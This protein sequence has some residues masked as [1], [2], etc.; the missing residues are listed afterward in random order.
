MP[1]VKVGSNQDGQRNQESNDVISNDVTNINEA[2]GPSF[3]VPTFSIKRIPGVFQAESPVLDTPEEI[4]K[5]ALNKD[6]SHFIDR[7]IRLRELHSRL[8]L[9]AIISF[10]MAVSA[11]CLAVVDIE[12]SKS[13]RGVLARTLNCEETYVSGYFR[14][15]PA[16]VDPDNVM[17]DDLINRTIYDELIRHN[18]YFERWIFAHKSY[19]MDYW[20]VGIVAKAIITI[21]SIA[22][23]Y[24]SVSYYVAEVDVLKLKRYLPEDGQFA[25]SPKI[26]SFAL[27][28]LLLFL[29]VPPLTDAWID[30]QFQLLVGIRTVVTG[31]KVLKE[32][33]ELRYHGLGNVLSNLARIKI[34]GTFLL[35]TYFLRYPQTSLLFVYL[36][37]IAVLPYLLML[38]EYRDG[39]ALSFQD[40][41]WLMVVTVTNL[42]S[43]EVRPHTVPARAVVGFASLVG[44]VTTALWV[45]VISKYMELPQEER[46]ILAMVEHQRIRNLER[47]KAAMCIQA[48]WRLFH[49]QQC[50]ERR[51]ARTVFLQKACK[52]AVWDWKCIRQHCDRVRRSMESTFSTEDT[53]IVARNMARRMST[54]ESPERPKKSVADLV[55]EQ[56]SS[57]LLPTP[58]LRPSFIRHEDETIA[59][60][61]AMHLMDRS[62]D[63]WGGPNNA[64]LRLVAEAISSL[65]N[66]MAEMNEQFRKSQRR[67]TSQLK[68]LH[69]ILEKL[70]T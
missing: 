62:A 41:C 36:A 4:H 35:K 68:E 8:R 31:V 46:R 26:K 54:K 58:N 63:N 12:T 34:H 65:N 11:S 21:L 6:F 22:G 50:G 70:K 37:V 1:N 39:H 38:A 32:C 52:K 10:A 3:T 30:P 49:Y 45:N 51:N 64:Q 44:I 53:L 59:P 17:R 40:A 16:L 15:C 61:A 7:D 55:W 43:G 18:T 27:K 25:K 60:L 56:R 48:A 42:G 9:L 33:N 2:G 66:Q 69:N 20:V 67:M 28:T 13:T 29:H 24:C 14:T 5:Q 23:T 19:A 57:H 47:R